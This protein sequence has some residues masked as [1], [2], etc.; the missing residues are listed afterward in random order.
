MS[1]ES[2]ADLGIFVGEPAVTEM[3]IDACRLDRA[4]PGQRLYCNRN[5]RLSDFDIFRREKPQERR[6]LL[7]M[8]RRGGGWYVFGE[9]AVDTGSVLAGSG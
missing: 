9:R 7:G 3:Q 8:S 1:G 5:T 6:V 4:M 2:I